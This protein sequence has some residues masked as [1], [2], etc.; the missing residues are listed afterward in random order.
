MVF[1]SELS[2]RILLFLFVPKMIYLIL[3]K[4]YSIVI[5]LLMRF[6]FSNTVRL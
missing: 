3:R 2:P 5:S 1:Y 6:R 4:L